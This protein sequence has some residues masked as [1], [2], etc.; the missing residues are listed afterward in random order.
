MVQ[1]KKELALWSA[2]MQ[3]SLSAWIFN[4]KICWS[5]PGNSGKTK[6]RARLPEPE[7]FIRR[8]QYWWCQFYTTIS[9]EKNNWKLKISWAGIYTNK[10]V[11][12]FVSLIFKSRFQNFI[13]QVLNTCYHS[14]PYEFKRR[15]K[16]IS[17]FSLLVKFENLELHYFLKMLFFY[18]CYRRYSSTMQD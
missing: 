10:K 17:T 3:Y 7:L 1:R 8:T 16:A 18:R 14:Y 9:K 11:D 15:S 12:W 13:I 4:A 6:Q 2:F 5:K